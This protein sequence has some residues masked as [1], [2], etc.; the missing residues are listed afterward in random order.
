MWIER[1]QPFDRRECP[2]DDQFGQQPL[3]DRADLADG[4]VRTAHHHAFAEMLGD[5]GPVGGELTLQPLKGGQRARGGRTPSGDPGDTRRG[6][7]SVAGV[8]V[9]DVGTCHQL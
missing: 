3:R 1:G 9:P 4:A 2:A 7:P 8:E 6:R 5:F